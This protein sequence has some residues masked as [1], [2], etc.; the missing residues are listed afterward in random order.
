M[1]HHLEKRIENF[2]IDHRGCT[3]VVKSSC[4]LSTKICQNHLGANSGGVQELL[5]GL[6]L[7]TVFLCPE[8]VIFSNKAVHIERS[9][10]EGRY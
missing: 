5:N 9:D 8:K 1:V 6:N 10:D 4:D 3:Q 7:K 2:F